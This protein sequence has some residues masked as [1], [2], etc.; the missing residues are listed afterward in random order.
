MKEK[1]GVAWASFCRECCV[2]GR[3]RGSQVESMA[4]LRKMLI[5]MINYC[6]FIGGDSVSYPQCSGQLGGGALILHGLYNSPKPFGIS[7]TGRKCLLEKANLSFPNLMVQLVTQECISR[8]FVFC[9]Q[10]LPL[11]PKHD[12]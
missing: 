2:V 6:R 7:A 8:T 5:E 1:R 10:M 11:K 12:I 3:G 9:I 4:S